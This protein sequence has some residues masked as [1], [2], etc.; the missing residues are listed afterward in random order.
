[1]GRFIG[2]EEVRLRNRLLKWQYIPLADQDNLQ[3]A[4]PPP[5][6]PR[7]SEIYGPNRFL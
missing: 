2:E 5:V 7:A 1:M 3:T 4:S 6:L